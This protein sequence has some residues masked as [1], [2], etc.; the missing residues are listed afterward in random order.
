MMPPATAAP[1]AVTAAYEHLRAWAGGTAS[2]GPRPTGLALVLQRGLAAWLAATDRWCRP[3]AR[4][5]LSPPAAAGAPAGELAHVLAAMVAACQQ[6]E[7][8]R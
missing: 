8:P 2:P 3:P 7:V 5:A 4:S 6:P 1:A